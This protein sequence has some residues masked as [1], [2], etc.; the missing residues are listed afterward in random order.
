MADEATVSVL[1]DYRKGATNFTARINDKSIT[2]AGTQH[3]H[4]RQNIGITEEIISLHEDGST[5]GLFFCI[6]RDGTNFIS[7][8]AA[9]GE[10]DIIRVNAGEFALFRIHADAT[11]PY[12]IADTA[13]CDLEYW[14]LEA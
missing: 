1:M 7:I 14:L 11:A 10:S 2:V 8:R 3:L 13:A 12:A 4:H 5:E 9:T 6:N